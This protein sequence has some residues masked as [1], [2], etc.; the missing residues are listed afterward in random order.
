ME[1]TPAKLNYRL[2]NDADK[3][4]IMQLWEMES[5]WGAITEQQFDDWFLNTPY[6]NCLSI[7]AVNDEDKVVGQ[8]INSPSRIIT[9]GREIKSLKVAAPVMRSDFRGMPLSNFDHPAFGMIKASFEIGFREGYQFAFG[10]PAFGWLAMFKSFPKIFPNPM[11][12]ISLDCFAIS[13]EDAATFRHP[14]TTHTI[15]IGNS[16]SKEYSVLFEEAVKEMNIKCTVKREPGWLGYVLADHLILELR[17]TENIL[18]G[19][20]AINKKSGLLIDILAKNIETL[21]VTYQTVVFALH[22]HNPESIKLPFN[23]LKGMLT[24]IAAASIEKI[25]YI[26]ENYQFA[27]GGFLLDTSIP[28]EELTASQWYMTP[29]S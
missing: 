2:Y 12:T 5:G 21:A 10:Y 6:G 19:Y 28:F 3:Q 4:A 11:E 25:I 29:I 13:L 18:E 14:G 22:Q 1:T 7:V 24:G 23:K 26:K 17:N 27:Y 15:N 8:I 9:N 16:F 20:A